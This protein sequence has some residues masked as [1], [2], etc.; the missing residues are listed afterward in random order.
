MPKKYIKTTEALKV[1]NKGGTVFYE[2]SEGH[3]AIKK[4][5]TAVYEF[6][7][8]KNGE[9]TELQ[10]GNMQNLIKTFNRE[11]ATGTLYIEDVKVVVASEKFKFSKA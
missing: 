7:A 9:Q 5:S 6:T 1:V 10:H 3:G 8:F 11:V 4:K 2:L